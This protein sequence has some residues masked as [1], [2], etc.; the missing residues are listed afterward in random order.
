MY[1]YARMIELL[2]SAEKLVQVVADD[3]IGSD[4]VRTMPS[5]SP[6]SATAHVEAPRGTLIHDY[7]V[8]ANGIVT[9]AN[10]LVAT[11][12]NLSSINRTIGL[13]AEQY[14]DKPD[15]LLLNAIEF[16]VRCYDPCLSCA[17][18]RLG[19]MRLDVTIRQGGRVVR[20]ARR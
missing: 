19:E 1:H 4:H 12:Q 6:R 7:E 11:Q 18:H 16:G 9:K 3:E 17:T 15:D 14:L 2:Y 5:G 20:T 8:D 10:L 13:S